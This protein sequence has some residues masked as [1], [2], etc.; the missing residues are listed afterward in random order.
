MEE[1]KTESRCPNCN[2]FLFYLEADNDI[3]YE[4]KITIH[5]YICKKCSYRNVTIERHD[6]ESPKIIKFK[7]KN[8]NDLKTIVYRSPDASVQIPEL[9]AE[10]SPGI[11][12]KGYIT[13]V[14]GILTSIK[15]KLTIMG[16]G[17]DVNYL[18]QRIEGIISGVEEKVTIVIDDDSGKSRINSS[19]AEIIQKS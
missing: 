5:T 10:I 3:P 7:I 8:K 17:E 9:D 19:R 4:G 12:S 1:I 2:A 16:D 11:A 6:K 14:E 15:E 13:T 18:M